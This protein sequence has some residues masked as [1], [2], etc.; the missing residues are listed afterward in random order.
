MIIKKDDPEVEIIIHVEEDEEICLYCEHRLD[1]HCDVDN[2]IPHE[3][4]TYCVSN[5][6][7]KELH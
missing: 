1:G 3:W 6:R 4:V 7:K 5:I 2:L